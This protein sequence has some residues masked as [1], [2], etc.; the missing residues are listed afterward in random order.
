M[1]SS[2]PLVSSIKLCKGPPR[3]S[4]I[5]GSSEEMDRSDSA[6]PNQLRQAA[7]R[8][9]VSQSAMIGNTNQAPPSP[10][11]RVAG[12][13]KQEQTEMVSTIGFS[14]LNPGLHCASR[15]FRG[16]NIFDVENLSG[17][18]TRAIGIQIR[19]VSC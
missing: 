11:S 15:P 14:C 18:F 19:N 6:I 17:N 16:T 2:K 3:H 10:R 4:L 5:K 12:R 9:A 13:L 7:K 1:D 8:D